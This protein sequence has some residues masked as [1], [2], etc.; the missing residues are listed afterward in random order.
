MMQPP[1]PAITALYAALVALILL[2]LAARVSSFRMRLKIHLGD[3]GEPGLQRAIRAHANAVEWALP[4]LALML[5]A[6]LNRA[7]PFLLHLCGIVLVIARILHGTG[8]SR[9]SGSSFGR[10]T[11]IALTWAVLAVLA[12]WDLWAFVRT[13]EVA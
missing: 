4:V 1:M 6:E 9:A 12:L 5:I 13:L 7:S 8:L 11:G 3:G 10:F 2:A